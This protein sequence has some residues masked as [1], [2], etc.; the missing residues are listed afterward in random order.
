MSMRL[1]AIAATSPWRITSP[2]KHTNAVADFRAVQNGRTLWSF[3]FHSQAYDLSASDDLGMVVFNGERSY[4]DE[5]TSGIPSSR[6]R[7]SSGARA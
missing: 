1:G 6:R 2:R 7:S 5:S 3:R 4:I